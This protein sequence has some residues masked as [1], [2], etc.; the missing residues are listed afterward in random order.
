MSFTTYD[1]GNSFFFN[2]ETGKATSDT[3]KVIRA[4]VN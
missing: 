1:L 2:D 4:P 3:H